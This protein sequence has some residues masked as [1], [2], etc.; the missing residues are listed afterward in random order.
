M[1]NDSESKVVFLEG[2]TERV[3]RGLIIAEDSFFVT[4]QRRDGKVRIA[5]S[6][7]TKIDSRNSGSGNDGVEKIEDWQDRNI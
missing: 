1:E 5:K 7:I 2:N 4:L 6:R 3:L